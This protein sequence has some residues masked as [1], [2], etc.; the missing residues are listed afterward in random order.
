MILRAASFAVHRRDLVINLHYPA[1]PRHLRGWTLRS[2]EQRFHVKF[3]LFR[4][5]PRTRREVESIFIRLRGSRFPERLG[6]R[7]FVRRKE[8][9][10]RRTGK[11]LRGPGDS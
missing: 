4:S 8:R 10:E 9:R 7:C 3:L 11:S 1:I 5:S 2:G 6:A